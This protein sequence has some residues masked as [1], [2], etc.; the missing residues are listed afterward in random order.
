MDLRLLLLPALIAAPAMLI[1]GATWGAN[2]L[3]QRTARHVASRP[4][5][6]SEERARLR[7]LRE[8]YRRQADRH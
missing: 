6:T 2:A 7:T 5:F 1:L 3:A 8:R 4:R